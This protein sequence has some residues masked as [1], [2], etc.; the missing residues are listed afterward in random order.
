MFEEMHVSMDPF[1]STKCCLHLLIVKI[2]KGALQPS[3]NPFH[4]PQ[5]LTQT[6]GLALHITISSISA[7]MAPMSDSVPSQQKHL[8][9]QP[10]LHNFYAQRFAVGLSAGFN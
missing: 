5:L 3:H 2:L 1:L 9:L 7:C 10:L 8:M 4:S 6:P